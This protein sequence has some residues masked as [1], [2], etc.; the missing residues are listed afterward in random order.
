MHVFECALLDFTPVER[1]A[2]PGTL[3]VIHDV[4]PANAAR[5]ARVGRTPVWTGDV[6]KLHSCLAQVR[7]DL[8]L[9]PMNTSP[10]AMRWWQDSILGGASGGSSAN[11]PL[12]HQ[13]AAPGPPAG[14]R[15]ARGSTGPYD[16]RI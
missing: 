3:V 8:V 6:W 2:R 15:L 4:L 12:R 9:I 16:P 5:G 11:P 1:I 10:T 13:V 7:P 14:S